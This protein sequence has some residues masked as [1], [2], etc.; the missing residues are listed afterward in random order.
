[1][2]DIHDD[3]IWRFL[4]LHFVLGEFADKPESVISRTGGGQIHV[5][6]DLAN[7]LAVYLS[8]VLDNYPEAAG[9]EVVKMAASISGM[10]GKY[11]RDGERYDPTFWTNAGF[12]RHDGWLSIRK[13]CRELLV[14]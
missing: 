8:F 3:H 13:K 5:A 1:M 2:I 10:L 6:D 9:L 7:H 14:R 4:Q 11:T 12:I